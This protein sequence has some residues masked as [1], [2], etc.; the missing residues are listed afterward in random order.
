M[1]L[2]PS[3]N[4]Q[5]NTTD[6]SGMPKLPR[7]QLAYARTAPAFTRAMASASL[8]GSLAPEGSTAAWGTAVRSGQTLT[9]I[10]REQ[11]AA[12][13]VNISNNEAM[14][15]AQTVARSNNIANPNM[16][17]PGQQL[18][19]DS[20]NFS[21]QQA[22]AVNQAIAANKAAAA[23]A[24]APAVTPAANVNTL[25]TNTAL[26]S[27]TLAGTAQVQ[28]LTRSDRSGNVV[29]EKTI[30]RAIEKGF[31]PAQDKQA[32]MNKIVQLSQEHRFAPDDFARLTLME[33]DGMNPKASNSRCHGIIQFCDGPDRG[34]A[35][36]GFGANPK[37]ILGHSV[38]QQ[39]DMVGKYF[40]DTGLKNFG[41][42]GLDDLYLTVLT[43]AARNETRPNAALNIPGQQAAY[44]HVNRDMRAPIT[45]NSILAGLHQ[46]ANERL[47]TEV[48]Q[49]PSMQAARLSAY[50]AQAAVTEA[51]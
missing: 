31:I 26:G 34:A 42:V 44:L 7:S 46:N 2:D 6:A 23:S 3:Y 15:L 24:A 32:V 18:N 4:P 16:I 9:G 49:R 14:R 21:L 33:S 48:A 20:L 5:V 17:H 40:D 38:L 25:N 1:R 30:D 22:Q 50:A 47:G 11:M 43:P 12:R 37:A 51:R 27:A 13:G 45:R 39:L 8:S 29:L 36:A 35:S 10:V 28:L 41:P 19:L